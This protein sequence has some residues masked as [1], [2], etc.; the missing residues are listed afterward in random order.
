MYGR[1]EAAEGIG[2]NKFDGLPE[3]IIFNYWYFLKINFRF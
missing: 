1:I 2:A 3:C